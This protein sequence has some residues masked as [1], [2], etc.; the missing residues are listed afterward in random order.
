MVVV[1]GVG[2]GGGASLRLPS[3]NT[4]VCKILWLCGAI[5]SLAF[6]ESPLNFV[7]SL[8][9]PFPGLC[10]MPRNWKKNTVCPDRF[11][12]FDVE[13]SIIIFIKN[14]FIMKNLTDLRKTVE[15][16]V[17]PRLTTAEPRLTTTS[18]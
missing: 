13:S 14:M 8:K 10:L 12:D 5:L 4:N 17:D 15:T 11:P 9:F 16:G 6:N 3:H 2:G 7:I 1:G 18:L